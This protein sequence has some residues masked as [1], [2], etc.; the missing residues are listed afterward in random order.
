MDDFV[1]FIIILVWVIIGIINFIKK[2]AEMMG[3]GPVP[4]SGQKPLRP[5]STRTPLRP[6]IQQRQPAQM[7]R[8]PVPKR[9]ADGMRHPKESKAMARMMAPRTAP[10]RPEPRKGEEPRRE[11][12]RRQALAPGAIPPPR[13]LFRSTGNP[14]VDGIIFYELLG[15]PLAKRP[16]G[17]RRLF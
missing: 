15:K 7:Q 14:L 4:K 13:R 12:S 8:A 10:P 5:E 11:K 1:I 16:P 9:P 6:P 3:P 17:Q 2:R